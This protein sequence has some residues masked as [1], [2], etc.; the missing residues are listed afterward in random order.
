MFLYSHVHVLPLGIHP[1]YGST[2]HKA[3]VAQSQKKLLIIQIG[4][5]LNQKE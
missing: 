1:P 3:Y 5:S 4:Y 2:L